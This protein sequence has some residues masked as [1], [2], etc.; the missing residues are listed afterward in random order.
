MKDCQRR[1]AWDKFLLIALLLSLAGFVAAMFYLSANWHT[2]PASDNTIA[3]AGRPG[4][5]LYIYGLTFALV[6]LLLGLS[7]WRWHVT[8]DGQGQ[9]GWGLLIISVAILVRV[10]VVLGSEPRL[11]DDIWRYIHDGATL[12]RGENPYAQAPADVPADQAP[13]PGVLARINNAHLITAYQ[14]VSQYVFVLFELAHQGVDA[15][16]TGWDVNHDRTFRLGLVLIEMVLIVLLIVW[17][18]R[19][20][21]S[22]WW[23]SLYAWHPLAISEVAGTGHQ[24]VIGLLPMFAALMLATGIAPMYIARSNSPG[25]K[26]GVSPSLWRALS[27][28]AL[29]AL[30]AAVKPIV[31]PLFLPIAWR[32]RARRDLWLGLF[33]AAAVVGAILY[34]PFVFMDGGLTGMVQTL[35]TFVD[36][37]AFN[38]SIYPLLTLYPD[39]DSVIDPL[40]LLVLLGVVIMSIKAGHDLWQTTVLYLLTSLLLS[41]TVHPWYLL[42]VLILMPIRFSAMLW[43]FSVTVILS[44]TAHINAEKFQPDI[45]IVAVEYLL[46]Y[47]AGAALWRRNCKKLRAPSVGRNAA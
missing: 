40:L 22:V 31:L 26:A 15:C 13:V 2:D 27:C 38:G 29:L 24:D 14:P 42:W 8:R 47:G 20:G 12:A 45:W 34:L 19:G 43:V 21:R 10:A 5:S 36:K 35:R 41:S 7:V 16:F 44:Y 17:L 46:V 30:A 3:P 11:S 39:S 4:L 6:W 1:S 9:R 23:T 25:R 33:V 28:G 18:A 32:W 37:W